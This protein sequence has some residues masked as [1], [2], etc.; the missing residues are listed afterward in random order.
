MFEKY[1]T[2]ALF[3]SKNAVLTA[4]SS[5]KATSLVL[6]SGG[7]TTSVVPVHDGYALRKGIVMS[8]LAGNRITE[9]LHKAV[10]KKGISIKPSFMISRRAINPNKDVVQFEVKLKDC[11]NTTNSYMNYMVSNVVRDMKEIVCRVSEAPFDES[12]HSTISTMAYELPDGNTVEVGTDRFVVPELMFNPAPLNVDASAAPFTGVHQMIYDSVT[13]CDNDIRRELFNSV[14]VTG[15]NTLLAGFHERLIYELHEVA[16]Q[17]L[18]YKVKVFSTPNT[19]ERK[20]SVWIGGS[21]L[22]SLGS[23][24]QMWIS[25]SEYEEYG[26]SVVEKKCP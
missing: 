7:G 6:D 2:P 24:Q 21:I 15:G 1:K 9:E 18:P 16:P 12:A 8:T 20:F 4:F 11:P 13:K 5:G 19:T 25:K 3:Q 22:A 26:S 10:E 14:I 23:F 17:Q